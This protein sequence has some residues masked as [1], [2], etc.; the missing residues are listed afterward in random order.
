ML[1]HGDVF[2]LSYLCPR[3]WQR[4]PFAWRSGRW[5]RCDP[6]P[7]MSVQIFRKELRNKRQISGEVDEWRSRL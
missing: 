4:D 1:R 5:V 7:P 2:P 3:R 6:V